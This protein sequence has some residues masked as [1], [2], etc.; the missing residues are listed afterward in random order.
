[1]LLCKRCG[2]PIEVHANDAETFEGMHWLCFHLEFE[3][4]GDP[5]GPCS[6]PSCPWWHLAVLRSKLSSLGQD[7]NE[8]IAA[9]IAARWRAPS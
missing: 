2:K 3:H 6:D 9:A 4:E 5:D 1:M 8:V 7:P